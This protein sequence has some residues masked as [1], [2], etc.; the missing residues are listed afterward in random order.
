MPYTSTLDD[1]Y[2]EVTIFDKPAMFTPLRI[3]RKT[4]PPGYYVYELRHDD[5]FKGY[6]V[7]IGHRI[8]VNHWGSL[9]MRDEVELPRSGCMEIDPYSLNYGTG[10]CR[11]MKEYFEKY[12]PTVKPP[13]SY[14]R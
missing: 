8:V 7:E 1:Y 5:E 3:N 12:P 9:I 6:A 4:V 11:S 2:E 10:D 14:E 13:K